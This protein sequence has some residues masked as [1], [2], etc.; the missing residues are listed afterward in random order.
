[1]L[2]A[3]NELLRFKLEVLFQVSF[4]LTGD[5]NFYVNNLYLLLFT[6]LR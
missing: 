3:R 2:F 5:E 4:L 1:M 6:Q